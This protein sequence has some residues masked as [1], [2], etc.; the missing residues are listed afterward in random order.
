MRTTVNS[1]TR[2][3]KANSD[4]TDIG[5]LR[6]EAFDALKAF[7]K[8]IDS[9]ASDSEKQD[10]R[11]DVHSKMMRCVECVESKCAEAFDEVPRQNARIQTLADT[12]L[13]LLNLLL[14]YY[15]VIDRFSDR[16]IPRGEASFSNLQRFV[17]YCYPE[18]AIELKHD[19]MNN[20]LPTN[21]FDKPFPPPENPTFPKWFP[22]AGAVFGGCTLLFF[23][24]VVLASIFGHDVSLQGRFIVVIVWAFGTAL[25]SAFLGGYAAAKGSIPFPF[26][27]EHPVQFTVG[28]GIAVLFITALL[29]YYLY[30]Q[31]AQP[32]HSKPNTSVLHFSEIYRS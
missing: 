14:N 26:V 3:N 1:S 32:D 31:P 29:G 22:I 11:L 20:N 21:G 23:M 4:D 30:V 2:M 5:R 18:R 10:A 12:S 27:R 16:P 19:Y 25:S 17:S 6:D 8:V 24:G 9:D 13:N 15:K 28:G 7:S